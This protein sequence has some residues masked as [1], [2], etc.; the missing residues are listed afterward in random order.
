MDLYKN[1]TAYYVKKGSRSEKLSYVVDQSIKGMNYIRKKEVEFDY[2]IKRVC[3]W[4][5]LDRKTEIHDEN[6]DVDLN[7]LETII[8]KN[9]LV[10]WK[11][12]MILWNYEPII[13][14]NYK[15]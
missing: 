5:I 3:I 9:R 11:K 8:F 4:I 6:N 7:E 2:E 14:I 10:E 13:Q 12:Q 1:K 15:K